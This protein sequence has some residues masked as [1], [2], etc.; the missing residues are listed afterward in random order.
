MAQPPPFLEATDIVT[1]EAVPALAKLIASG[2]PLGSVQTSPW[3]LELL[4][5]RNRGDVTLRAAVFLADFIIH[6]YS[7]SNPGHDWANLATVEVLGQVD[8]STMT[9]PCIRRLLTDAEQLFLLVAG[10]NLKDA[11]NLARS[12]NARRAAAAQICGA[13]LAPYLAFYDRVRDALTPRLRP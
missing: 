8:T 4:R 11:G 5:L 2:L 9:E 1:A 12:V 10:R 13:A 6:H 7:G 3:I